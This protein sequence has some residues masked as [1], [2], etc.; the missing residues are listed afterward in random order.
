[1]ATVTF[2]HIV[3][4]ARSHAQRSAAEMDF[5]LSSRGDDAIM[6]LRQAAWTLANPDWATPGTGKTVEQRQA[7]ADALW[8]RVNGDAELGSM[9]ERAKGRSYGGWSSEAQ[10]L[11]Q[12]IHYTDRQA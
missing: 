2:A 9:I 10:G 4:E 7:A 8:D 6:A 1:M 5:S 3:M 12:R 11:G